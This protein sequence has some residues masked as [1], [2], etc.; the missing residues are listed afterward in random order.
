MVQIKVASITIQSAYRTPLDG[1]TIRSDE[2]KDLVPFCDLFG[3]EPS[4][5]EDFTLHLETKN[6]HFHLYYMDI[7]QLR[8]VLR[9]L[10][11]RGLCLSEVE[12]MESRYLGRAKT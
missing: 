9:E 3:L 2:R 6:V 10:S 7:N 4:I 5:H 8:V 1:I 12:G 11:K